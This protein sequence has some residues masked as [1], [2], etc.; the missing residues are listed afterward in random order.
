MRLLI[1]DDEFIIRQGLS[2]LDWT[3][4]GINTVVTAEDAYI[5]MDELKRQPFDVVLSD[6]RMSGMTGL[7]LAQHIKD[8]YA[9]TKVVLLTGFSDFN[10][11]IEAIHSDV[12]DYILKP[13]N[14]TQL[15]ESIG[16]ALAEVQAIKQQQDE[17]LPAPLS[18]QILAAF[19]QASEPVQ[20]LLC[21][22]AD[23]YPE[24]LSLSSLSQTFH[25]TTVHLSRIIKKDTG[26]LF[27]DILQAIRLM[28]ATR[29]LVSSNRKVNE[30]CDQTGFHDQRYFSQVF[31]RVMGTSPLEYR[32]MTKHHDQLSFLAMLQQI[33]DLKQVK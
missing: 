3:S 6:I 17:V 19:C 5:A 25:F 24:N 7:A 14:P 11:A 27:V 20:Q 10:Y 32:R 4:I 16:K 1:V 30:I 18:N 8:H 26:Y 33:T 28:E 23:H 9:L 21:Y 31:K 13:I 2:S 22:L 29:L 12:F 15:F